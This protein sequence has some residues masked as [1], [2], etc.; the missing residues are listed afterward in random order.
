MNRTTPILNRQAL[1]QPTLEPSPPK[2]TLME[3]CHQVYKGVIRCHL[4]TAEVLEV[5]PFPRYPGAMNFF[6]I[7]QD[8]WVRA[9]HLRSAIKS[10]DMEGEQDS[11]IS[12]LSTPLILATS[13]FITL[14]YLSMLG[15]ISHPISIFLNPLH[16]FSVILCII[17][18]SFDAVGLSRSA[19]FSSLFD[20]KMLKNLALFR[21]TKEEKKRN[22]ALC[23]ILSLVKGKKSQFESVYGKEQTGTLLNCLSDLKVGIDRLEGE[24][25]MEE[26]SRAILS[27]NL[28]DMEKN[29]LHLSE[30]GVELVAKR[31]LEK[32]RHKSPEEQEELL[33]LR[34]KEA[35]NNKYKKLA[36]R[37]R[38]WMADE[39]NGKI[40]SILNGLKSLSCEEQK[41]A[42]DQGFELMEMARIQ[43]R[44][45]QIIHV[46]GII[47]MTLAIA[48]FIGVMVGTP[49]TTL[50]VLGV[51][52]TLVGFGRFLLFSGWLDT[53]GWHFSKKSLLPLFVQKRLF[54]Q[55]SL[56]SSS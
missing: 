23:S 27:K 37:V 29:Y 44:K 50:I 32:E 48:F 51:L 14:D 3:R 53:R 39:I 43:N 8:F 42:T 16:I 33:A 52:V 35:L 54:S 47:C 55:E 25:K 18:G 7:F 19:E 34:L 49:L 20:F 11:L 56:P 12:T 5:D 6:C 15:W 38:P 46:I 13:T 2:K 31:V 9:G 28:C 45:K 40:P 36:R 21:K 10:S 4:E 30:E 1:L 41:L 24:Q 26:L 22:Q 17:E